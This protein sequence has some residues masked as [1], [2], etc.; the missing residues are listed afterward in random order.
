[1]H[2]AARHGEAGSSPKTATH[3]GSTLGDALGACD[4]LDVEGAFVSGAGPNVVHPSFVGSDAQNHTRNALHA[5]DVGSAVQAAAWHG[6]SGASPKIVTQSGSALGDALGEALGGALGANDGLDVDLGQ[7]DVHP[8]SA[9]A[10]AP[11]RA[12][13]ACTTEAQAGLSS[14]P[15]AHAACPHGEPSPLENM[16]SQAISREDGDALGDGVVGQ[17]EGAGEGKVVGASVSRT[18]KSRQPSTSAIVEM[19]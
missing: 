3:V 12:H 19:Q 15:A 7:C 16:S 9:S 13:H 18:E 11:S 2:T 4:G 5:P 14:N 17:E 1:M 6:D 8:F 10:P